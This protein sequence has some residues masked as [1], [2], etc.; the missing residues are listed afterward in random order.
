ME[1]QDEG[2]ILGQCAQG[3]GDI[4]G[5]L[6]AAARGTDLKHADNKSD[7]KNICQGYR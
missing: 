3:E 7:S 2:I 6:S 1:G 4:Q 5:G